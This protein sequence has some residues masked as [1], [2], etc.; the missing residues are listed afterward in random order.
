MAVSR[1]ETAVVFLIFAGVA[2]GVGWGIYST[3]AANE[4]KNAPARAA[5]FL[6]ANDMLRAKSL[7]FDSPA[8]WRAEVERRTEL[9]RFAKAQADA[10]AEQIRREEEAKTAATRKAMEAIEAKEKAEADAKEKSMNCAFVRDFCTR[11]S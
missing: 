6:D 8:S 5:G 10:K 1:F 2:G 7:G 11:V 9:E 3:V 4:A